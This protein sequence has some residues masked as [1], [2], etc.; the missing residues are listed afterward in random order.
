[1]P[2]ARLISTWSADSLAAVPLGAL[3]RMVRQRDGQVHVFAPEPE[4][5]EPL[6]C[7]SGPCSEG[8]R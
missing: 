8:R 7:A 4:G 1:M 6:G 3:R 2:G 5:F